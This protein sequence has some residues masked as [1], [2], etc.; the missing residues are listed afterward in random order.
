MI[1]RKGLGIL[2]GAFF[3]A[4]VGRATAQVV[5]P[6]A[7]EVPI[8]PKPKADSA[9]KADSLQKAD[10][11][12]AAFGRMEPP[13]TKDIGPPF[14][15]NREQLFASGAYTVAD[16]LERLPGATSFRTGWLASPKFVAVNGDFARVKVMYDGLEIDN[17]DPRSGPV[18]DL[19]SIDLWTLED[20]RIERFANELRVHLTSWRA[21]Q[22]DPYTRTDIFTGDE[23]TNIYRGF[24]GKRFGSGFGL[25]LAGQQYSTRSARLGGG[26]DALSFMGRIGV[27][28][29]MWSAD[30]FAVRRNSSHIIQPTFGTGLS[31]APFQGTQTIAYARVA[32]GNEAGGPWLQA[33]ASNM[34]LAESTSHVDAAQAF[35]RKIRPDT[36][37]TTTKRIQYLIAAGIT[38]GL[39]TGSI[40]DRVKAFQGEVRHSPELRLDLSG[41]FGG[42]DL[43]AQSEGELKRKRVDVIATLNPVSFVAISGAVSYDAP[44]NDVSG[45][46]ATPTAPLQRVDSLLPK[47]SSARIEAGVRLINPWLVGGFITRDTAVLAAPHIVDSAYRVRALGKRQGLYAG[48]RG[49]VFRDVNFEVLGTRWDSAGYY[50]PRYQSRSEINLDTRWLSRFPSGSFGLKV[51]G[52][53]E[54][55]GVVRFPVAGGNRSIASGN[56]FSA[57]LEIRILRGV[58]SYQVRNI[59]GELYQIFPDFYMP[60]S[61]GVYGIRWEFWN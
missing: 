37:D 61:V 44:E 7:S 39:F 58:A 47:M 27:A 4:P 16:L 14:R 57:L 25:Q 3:F 50:Q 28:R 15:W 60:R 46:S 18:L 54:Y 31:L 40:G 43:F 49:K 59:F 34:R 36:A 30:A 6:P 22:T 26:G 42:F 41:R 17:L 53:H 51:A 11:I 55:R 29:K 24:Y 38:R 52:I 8:P 45:A 48:L 33:T 1:S 56:V 2:V 10:T 13:R 21:K 23:D 12:Q 35:S 19:T 20:V 9:T 5:V 32:I